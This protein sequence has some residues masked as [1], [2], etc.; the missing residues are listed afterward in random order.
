[1]FVTE[2]VCPSLV[3]I[4]KNKTRV[5]AYCVLLSIRPMYFSSSAFKAGRLSSPLGRPGTTLVVGGDNGEDLGDVW[6]CATGCT[7]RGAATLPH[8]QDIHYVKC[9]TPLYPLC[10]VLNALVFAICSVKRPCIHYTWS[11]DC[12]LCYVTSIESRRSPSSPSS[13]LL[14]RR[15]NNVQ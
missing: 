6:L 10:G 15:H 13:P 3:L 11:A 2:Q 12:A 7:G 8:R 1:M 14:H 4:F 5:S 9:Q